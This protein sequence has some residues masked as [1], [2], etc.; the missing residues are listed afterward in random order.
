ME[1][2]TSGAVVDSQGHAKVA[3]HASAN[4]T[5]RD[6]G[7]LAE[8]DAESGEVEVTADV[9]IDIDVEATK[10]ARRVAS[11]ASEQMLSLAVTSAR[12]L[13]S[14][15]RVPNRTI[16]ATIWHKVTLN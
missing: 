11:S 1:V 14:I 6:F 8:L 5:R 3:F 12:N 15:T 16:G 2:T 7:L 10:A 4:L 13:N 9:A